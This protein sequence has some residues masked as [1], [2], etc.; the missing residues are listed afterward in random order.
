[1]ILPYVYRLQHKVTKQFYIGSRTNKL[2]KLPAEQDILLYKSSSKYVKDLGFENFDIE[3]IAIFFDPKDAYKF[4]QELIFVD[5]KNPLI[6]NKSCF[7]GK[8]QFNPSGLIVTEETKKKLSECRQGDKHHMYGKP[9]SNATKEKISNSLKGK[10]SGKYGEDH[11]NFGKIF[12]KEV[13]ERMSLSMKGVKRKPL[14]EEQKQAM[15]ARFT[16]VECPA[17]RKVS[18]E[19]ELEIYKLFKEG[20]IRKQLYVMYDFISISTIKKIIQKYLKLESE[21]LIW[22]R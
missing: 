1:M 10:Y 22:Q 20:F 6:L 19:Q 18:K 5:F 12:S 8:K 15:S 2:Q 17:R 3:I 14:T 11:H 7:H 16:G 21:G 4:E 13:R 9:L